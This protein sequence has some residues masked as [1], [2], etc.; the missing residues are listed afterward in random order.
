[1]I[2]DSEDTQQAIVK[3][4]SDQHAQLRA[5]AIEVYAQNHGDGAAAR[6]L[7]MFRDPDVSVQ[8]A[9]LSALSVIVASADSKGRIEVVKALAS[10]PDRRALPIYLDLLL[11]SNTNIRDSSR[12]TLLAMGDSV[13]S[14]IRTLHKRNELAT[15]VRRE[16]ARVFSADSQFAFLHE[17]IPPELEPS[18]YAQFATDHRGD[19]RRGQQLFA[20]P[21]GIGCAKCHV[22][23][24]AG[25]GNVGP[26]LLGIGAKYPR[27]ELIRSVLE[28]SNRIL[29]DFEMAVIVTINGAIHQ[30]M[31]RS[32]T[33]ERIEL[34]T[35]EG[36]VVPIRTDE[37]ELKKTS[38]LSPMPNGLANGMTLQNFADLIAYLESLKQPFPPQAE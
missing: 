2:S 24:G 26:D 25:T 10:V 32:Q 16:L 31:I 9:V 13:H 17:N 11:D 23:G 35:P 4:L 37:I 28:P 15:P 8:R 19:P 33:P 36:K 14:D 12:A 38:S 18:A 7:P 3:R 22:V 21:E 5:K 34:V 30:G 27:S 6:V 29:I 1:V 20:D